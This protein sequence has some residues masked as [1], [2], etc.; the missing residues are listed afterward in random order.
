LTATLATVFFDVDLYVDGSLYNVSAGTDRVINL[1]GSAQ[2]DEV[3]VGYMIYDGG[4]KFTG[5]MDFVQIY[6]TA[7]TGAEIA[8][9]PEPATLGM[10]VAV[11]GAALFIRRRKVM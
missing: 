3:S 1:G 2:P 5:T 4:R 6:D 10:I 8:A 7:L 9:I 11:G